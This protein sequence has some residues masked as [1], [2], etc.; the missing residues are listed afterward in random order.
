[1][2]DPATEVTT[3][4]LVELILARFHTTHRQELPEL[5]TLSRW[6]ETVHANDV[7]APHGL[8][9]ALE[10]VS[11][12]LEDH[13]RREEA[14]VFPALLDGEHAPSNNSF[15]HLR[16]DHAGQEAALNRIAAITHGFRLPSYACGSWRRL[17]AGLGKLAEDL[18]EHRYLEDD[19]LF[20]RF[21]A[22]RR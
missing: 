22:G 14:F 10:L 19:V 12:E 6:V 4:A 20:P 18:D 9:Q 2:H 21:E 11:V 5:V 8:A 15:D 17:Y 13:M 16:D 1:M 7:N 3:P